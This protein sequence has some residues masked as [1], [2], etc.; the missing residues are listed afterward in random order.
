M[1][2]ARSIEITGPHKA[3]GGDGWSIHI[4]IDKRLDG[5]HVWEFNTLEEASSVIDEWSEILS[6]DPSLFLRQR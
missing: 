1:S 5:I 3:P 4:G 6:N 2:K